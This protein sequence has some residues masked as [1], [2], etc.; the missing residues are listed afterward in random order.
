MYGLDVF[1]K[2]IPYKYITKFSKSYKFN[3]EKNFEILLNSEILKESKSL[4]LVPVVKSIIEE[5]KNFIKEFEDFFNSKGKKLIFSEDI[6]E[7]KKYQDKI[8]L[9]ESGKIKREDLSTFF[10]N[11]SLLSGEIIGWIF[12]D[13]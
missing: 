3:K 4:V 11:I 5:N 9:V 10:E 2:L 6:L 1:K 13:D 12:L 7:I 8:V